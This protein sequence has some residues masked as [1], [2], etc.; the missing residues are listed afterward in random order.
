MCICEGFNAVMTTH[1]HLVPRPKNEWSCTFTPQYAFMAWCLVKAE[2]QLYLFT[3]I[4]QEAVCK[5]KLCIQ[6]CNHDTNGQLRH[7]HK[8]ITNEAITGSRQVV[9]L[10]LGGWARG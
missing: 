7:Y 2:G 5:H 4:S 3:F 9:T 1:L 6:L 8:S 10:Q